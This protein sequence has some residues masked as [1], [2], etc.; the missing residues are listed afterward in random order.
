MT[1][2][3]LENPLKKFSKTNFKNEKEMIIYFLEVTNYDYINF[4]ELDKAEI[5][6][7][8]TLLVENSKKKNISDFDNI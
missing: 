1:T 3:T 7:E 4:N 5:D 6:D 8:L 2:I